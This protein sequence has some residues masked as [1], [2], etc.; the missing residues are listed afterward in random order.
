M[1]FLPVI[2]KVYGEPAFIFQPPAVP[3]SLEIKRC[4]SERMVPDG[5]IFSKNGVNFESNFKVLVP[6]SCFSG[7]LSISITYT[8]IPDFNIYFIRQTYCLV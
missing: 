5:K 8:E 7:F 4:H 3:A 1:Q 2:T 6:R